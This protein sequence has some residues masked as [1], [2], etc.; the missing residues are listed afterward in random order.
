M[1]FGRLSV[2]YKVKHFQL[3]AQVS[4]RGTGTLTDKTYYGYC[5]TVVIL[6]KNKF[7]ENSDN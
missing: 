4:Q 7:Q 3:S 5:F 6:R 1:C 2:A